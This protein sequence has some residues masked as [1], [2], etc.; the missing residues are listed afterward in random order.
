MARKSNSLFIVKNTK[1]FGPYRLD[2][3][4]HPFCVKSVTMVLLVAVA[5]EVLEETPV[6]V[7]VEVLEETPVTVAVETVVAVAGQQGKFLSSPP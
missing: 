3:L 6:V 5:V 7:A 4:H 2:S 1:S